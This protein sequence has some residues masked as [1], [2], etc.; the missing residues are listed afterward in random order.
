M[1]KVASEP[2][3]VNAESTVLSG[4]APA[5]CDCPRRLHNGRQGRLSSETIDYKKDKMISANSFEFVE[6]STH[7][8]CMIIKDMR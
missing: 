2:D 3:F 1:T 7:Q 8:K 4:I 6:N 5:R